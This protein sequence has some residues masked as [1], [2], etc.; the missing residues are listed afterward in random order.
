MSVLYIG[1]GLDT[2]ILKAEHTI[3]KDTDLFVFVDSLPRSSFG[4]TTDVC[5]SRPNFLTKL[6][7]KMKRL[8]YKIL[9]QYSLEEK[10]E[11]TYQKGLLIFYANKKF[12]YYFYSTTV[13]ISTKNS[14]LDDFIGKCSILYVQGHDPCRD[15]IKEMKKPITFIGGSITVF[16]TDDL[17][18]PV[19]SVFSN[20]KTHI[21]DI[22]SWYLLDINTYNVTRTDYESL[23]SNL[24]LR[25]IR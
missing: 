22:E 19:D 12:V 4:N 6:T 24:H 3:F 17:D 5:F 23:F 25:N 21:N 9:K 16:S 10:G 1:A 2:S 7:T 11:E 15:V 13:N 18:E 8:G 14:L 20:I